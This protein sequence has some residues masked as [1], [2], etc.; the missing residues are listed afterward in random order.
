M[1]LHF[2]ATAM[3]MADLSGA[4]WF[5]RA[6]CEI[7]GLVLPRSGIAPSGA[8]PRGLMAASGL[9]TGPRRTKNWLAS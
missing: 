3:V 9:C 8:H 1:H 6:D 4:R 7:R 5:N 2:A